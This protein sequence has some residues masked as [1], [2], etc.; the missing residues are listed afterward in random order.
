VP[1]VPLR[2]TGPG[3]CLRAV[4]GRPTH[5]C[6]PRREASRIRSL[7]VLD[8]LHQ[9][10][11]SR[12]IKKHTPEFNKS[13]RVSSVKDPPTCI[14]R[15]VPR[16]NLTKNHERIQENL[17]R[18]ARLGTG[19]EPLPHPC[20]PS[21]EPLFGRR[22]RDR[23]AQD[24]TAVLPLHPPRHVFLPLEF[25]IYPKPRRSASVCYGILRVVHTARRSGPPRR[26]ATRILETISAP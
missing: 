12:G 25:R 13:Q 2:V 4:K 19:I 7:I 24:F 10:L 26:S 15:R 22:E 18:P 20:A 17:T 1:S 8:D 9:P 6:L 14:L 11:A 23:D 16:Q 5:L 21:G 3:P